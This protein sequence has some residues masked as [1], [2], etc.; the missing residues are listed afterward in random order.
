[1]GNSGRPRTA[2][3]PANVAAVRQAFNVNPQCSAR[4]N[5]LPHISRSSFNRIAHRDIHW[6]P[7][8]IQK[9]HALDQGDSQR[10]LNFCHWLVNH[11]D[12]FLS[13]IIIGDEAA[14]HMNGE[15]NSWNVRCSAENRNGVQD[16]TYDIP[17]DQRKLLVWIGLVGDN[18]IIGPFFFDGNINGDT[19]LQMINHQVVP[20]LQRYGIQGNGALRRKW[21]FQDGAP[22]HRRRDVRDRLQELFPHRVVALGHQPEWPARSPDLTPLDFFLWGYLKERIYRT[23]PATLQDLRNRIT[24]EVQALR[25]TRMVRRAVRAMAQRAHRCIELHGAHVEGRAGLPNHH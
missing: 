11:P 9:R 8:H 25:R 14:F 21:W 15:V 7:Y 1:M 17:N 4:R 13:D 24:R 18:S 6:H 23:V 22:A 5:D 10:R 3:S 12:R 19:Y 20:E 2:R 16:F